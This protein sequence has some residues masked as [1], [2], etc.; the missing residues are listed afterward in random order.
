MALYLKGCLTPLFSCDA[1]HLSSFS[2]SRARSPLLSPLQMLSFHVILSEVL[3]VHPHDLQ[4]V[5]ANHRQSLHQRAD[6]H[7]VASE[8]GR[9]IVVDGEVW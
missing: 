2:L 3:A 5:V 9:S 1:L 8:I 7:H 6:G 4:H